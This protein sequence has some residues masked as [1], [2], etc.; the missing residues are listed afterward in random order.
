MYIGAEQ[1]LWYSQLRAR[2]GYMLYN[3]NSALLVLIWYY[4]VSCMYIIFV[5]HLHY[6]FS[7]DITHASHSP[8]IYVCRGAVR[9]PRYWWTINGSPTFIFPLF[10]DALGNMNPPKYSGTRYK[11][12]RYNKILFNRTRW[13]CFIF[14]CFC[15]L[16]L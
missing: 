1:T 2:R 15:T 8:R 10:C 6:S 14:H 13:F 12:V 9:F 3:G 7:F 11:E 4:F 5:V 16:I